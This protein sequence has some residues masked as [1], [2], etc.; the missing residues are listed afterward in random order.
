MCPPSIPFALLCAGVALH[1][2]AAEPSNCR[3]YLA[4]QYTWE[5]RRG[6]YLDLEG[7]VLSEL[8]VI[9]GTADGQGWAF[10]RHIPGFVTERDYRI[11]AVVAPHVGEIYV[12][13][14]RVARL[15]H[16]WTP[17]DG[18][19][20][21]NVRPSWA[22]EPG[23]WV[24]LMK[25]VVVE[26]VRDGTPVQRREIELHD[27]GEE[28]VPLRLFEAVRATSVSGVTPRRGDTLRVSV[29]LSFLDTDLRRWAPFVDRYGQSRHADYPGKVAS[30]S[31]LKADIEREDARLAAMPPPADLDRYGG[32]RGAP[33]KEDPTGFFRT[34]RRDGR[35]WLVTPEGNPCFYIGVCNVPASTWPT[36]P[37][38]GREFLFE[39]LPPREGAWNGAWSA[40]HW[41]TSDGTGYVCFYSANL[42]RKYGE[43]W[44]E[45][46]LGRAGRRLAAWG[47]MGG[48]KWG[49]PPDV[50][51]T[52]VLYPRATPRIGRHPDV[53]D[54][55]VKEA[56]RR[57]LAKQIEP[58]RD[59]PFVLGWSVG[60][61]YDE[62]VLPEEVTAVLGKHGA[63][64]AKRA[65][66]DRAVAARYGGD[67]ARTAAAWQV[68]ADGVDDLYES[69][70][71]LPAED[72]EHLRRFYADRYYRLIYETVKSIDPNHL[73]LGFW[74]VPGW[75]VNESDWELIAPHC[76][77]IG[78][79]RYDAS[80]ADERL[81][82]L[83]ARTDKPILCGEFSFPTW[84]GGRRG[85]GCYGPVHARDDEHAGE[86]YAQW[87][88]DASTDPYCVG[89][90]WFHYRDQPLTGRG[91]GTGDRLCY[92]E[93][94]AFGLITATDRPKWPMVE[95]MREA[96]LGATRHR[97]GLPPP[98]Q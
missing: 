14:R 34:V 37:V 43:G 82:R 40:G 79:D 2:G 32:T 15:E 98:R 17:D 69:R 63:V 1:V 36:T 25:A 3:L 59:D 86:L 49:A 73:Y 45:R 95:R 92:G 12:D 56:F 8:P 93:H 19:F 16:G 85:F 67:V 48:G 96:N 18:P 78:Y 26:V 22:T 46:A 35:W 28:D 30:D 50:V 10:T 55:D 47:F 42:I 84:Y 94:C 58:R 66:V 60:N 74:I 77:V 20:E 31:E 87:V 52:P 53:F 54:P 72:I 76:D 97:L 24:G 13:G 89:L 11:Q 7:T 65:L 9:L 33:W 81:T 21:V 70:P 88:R 39:W 68:E 41:G 44:R 83:A 80:F 4:G 91:P 6:F 29:R 62:H 27:G 61:E 75:W 64:P 71:T 5:G 38:T 51:S 90:L 23:D 57:D